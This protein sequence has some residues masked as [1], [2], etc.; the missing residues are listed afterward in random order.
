M[1]EKITPGTGNSNDR[2]DDDYNMLSTSR[3][4]NINDDIL[5]TNE[6][7]SNKMINTAFDLKR[8]VNVENNKLNNISD[9]D[10]EEMA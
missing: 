5:S 10:V 9:R 7:V 8:Q 3:N 1:D 2:V 4:T 6:T